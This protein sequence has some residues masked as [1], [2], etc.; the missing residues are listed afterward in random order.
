MTC[1]LRA[2]LCQD[3]DTYVAACGH[4]Y[5]SMTCGLR[6]APSHGSL[7]LI[8]HADRLSGRMLLLLCP[9]T[10]TNVSPYAYEC[11]PIRLRMCPHTRSSTRLSVIE[12]Q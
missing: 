3:E 12:P 11:V 1:G 8:P 5:R 9:H 7:A 4:V 10:L 6:A 2:A